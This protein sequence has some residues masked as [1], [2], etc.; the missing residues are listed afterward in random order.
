MRG[1]GS[2]GVG[3]VGWLVGL[4]VGRTDWLIDLIDGM[5]GRIFFPL[6]LACFESIRQLP[7]TISFSLFSKLP[8]SSLI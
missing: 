2:G 8:Q 1:G 4:T 5:I 6:C 3:L 7:L